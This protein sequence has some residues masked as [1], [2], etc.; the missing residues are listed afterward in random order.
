MIASLS[1][2]TA[3]HFIFSIAFVLGLVSSVLANAH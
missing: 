3:F 1:M 2:K